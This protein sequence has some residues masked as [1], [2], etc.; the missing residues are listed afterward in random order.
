VIERKVLAKS[1]RTARVGVMLFPVDRHGVRSPQRVCRNV[2]SPELSPAAVEP[3]AEQARV[4]V[5]AQRH[6][7]FLRYSHADTTWAQWLMRRLE[8]DRVPARF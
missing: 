3:A 1:W 6:R 7:V 4:A 5:A 8:D 2:K